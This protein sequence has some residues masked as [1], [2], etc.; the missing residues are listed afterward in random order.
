MTQNN[1]CI[2]TEKVAT[3]AIIPCH[4]LIY[5][6]TCYEQSKKHNINCCPFCRGEINKFVEI[7]DKYLLENAKDK[8]FTL[9]VNDIELINKISISLLTKIGEKC[10]KNFEKDKVKIIKDVTE[11]ITNNINQYQIY[12]CIE[13]TI[14]DNFKDIINEKIS[15]AIEQ[16]VHRYT[17]N[18]IKTHKEEINKAIKSQFSKSSRNRFL[19][20]SM[21]RYNESDENCLGME[22]SPPPLLRFNNGHGSNS[23]L[24]TYNN[25]FN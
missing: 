6:V 7:T 11:K 17:N 9:L 16:N 10:L 3:V 8:I 2:C 5:C 24:N 18:Y 4:H 22:D 25:I 20:N 15:N 13:K 21:S 12:E 1:C 14:R 23:F 19:Y